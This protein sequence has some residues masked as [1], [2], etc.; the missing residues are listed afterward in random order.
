MSKIFRRFITYVGKVKLSDFK[1]ADQIALVD[2]YCKE[3][4]ARDPRI[5]QARIQGTKLH[6]SHTDPTDPKEVLSIQFLDAE[7]QRVG[8]GHLHADGTAKF[9]YK[10]KPPPESPSGGFE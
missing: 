4:E 9:R 1:D 8:T 6:P 3:Q 2:K 10:Q 5:K 7:G